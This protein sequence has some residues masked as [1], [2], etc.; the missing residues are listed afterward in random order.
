LTIYKFYNVPRIIKVLLALIRLFGAQ[1]TDNFNKI[2]VRELSE[3]EIRGPGAINE[4]AFL[5]GLCL[6]GFCG[7]ASSIYN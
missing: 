2:V 6:C 7:T 4:G 1:I 5:P 3:N